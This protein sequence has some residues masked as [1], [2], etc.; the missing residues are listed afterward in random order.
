MERGIWMLASVVAAAFLVIGCGSGSGSGTGSPA[1]SNPDTLVTTTAADAVYSLERQI[2]PKV[3]S[4]WASWW[5]N[6]KTIKQ[7]GPMQVTIALKKP[8]VIFPQ[9]MATPAGTIESKAYLMKEGSKYGTPDGGVDCTGPF[10]LK[11]WN[12]GQS[13]VLARNANYWDTSLQAHAN[14][15]TFAFLDN[16]ATRASALQSGQVDGTFEV[17][18]T[19]INSL[20]SEERRVGQ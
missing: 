12:K 16:E 15:V 4:Y 5:A 9:M 19:A 11:K 2:N 17:P 10:S 1:K 14:E 18:P 7:T 8:D 13:I 3:G 20:R 6:V